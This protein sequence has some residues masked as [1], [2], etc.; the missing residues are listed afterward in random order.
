MKYCS[1]GANP[2]TKR[3]LHSRLKNNITAVKGGV[4]KQPKEESRHIINLPLPM[5]EDK[6]P[7]PP[8][9]DDLVR[10]LDVINHHKKKIKKL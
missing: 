2:K 1:R 10:L 7:P 5:M 4:E 8:N 9:T 3:V 6:Q